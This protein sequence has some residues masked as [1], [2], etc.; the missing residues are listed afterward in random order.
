M[1]WV[2]CVGARTCDLRLDFALFSYLVYDLRIVAYDYFSDT[3]FHLFV[4]M[5]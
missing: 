2:S 3:C 5:S 1:S 4:R